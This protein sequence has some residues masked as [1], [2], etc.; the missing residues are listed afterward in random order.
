MTASAR[1]VAK[2]ATVERSLNEAHNTTVLILNRAVTL[3]EQ[4]AETGGLAH[5][6]NIENDGRERSKA[7]PDRA[8]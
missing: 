3:I 2:P 8:V 4:F 1:L 5:D 6:A 7:M